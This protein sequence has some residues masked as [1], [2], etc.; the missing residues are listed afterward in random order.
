MKAA[1][2]FKEMEKYKDKVGEGRGKGNIAERMSVCNNDNLNGS[3][4]LL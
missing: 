3:D 1:R 2:K 4:V